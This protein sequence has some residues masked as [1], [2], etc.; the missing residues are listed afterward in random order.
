MES[1]LQALVTVIVEPPCV[2]FQS[3]S[4]AQLSS[5]AGFG[6]VLAPLAIT[7]ADVTLEGLS[8]I[9]CP[10]DTLCLRLSLDA[11]YASQS[12]E[13]LEVSLGGLVGATR[14][15]ATLGSCIDSEPQPLQATLT[16]NST[17][18]CMLVSIRIPTRAYSADLHVAV[19][20]AGQRLAGHPLARRLY[21]GFTAPLVLQRSTSTGG[22]GTTP[23][24][25]LQGRVYCPPGDGPEVV[26]F[27]K[28]G[29]PLPDLP[30]VSVGLSNQ[31]RWSAFA[32]GDS[33]TLL[34]AD[35]R[36]P[37]VAVDPVG[38]AIRWKCAE[39]SFDKCYGLA[40]L[41]S[42]GVVVSNHRSHLSAYRLT[43]GICLGRSLLVTGGLDLFLAADP[44]T[45]TV[46]GARFTGKE[47][48][49]T[50]HDVHSWSCVSV[51]GG[52][53]ITSAESVMFSSGA[54]S[55]PLAVM[56]AASGTL[57]SYLV[58]GSLDTD[59][60]RVISLPGLALVHTHRLEGMQV[61]GLA[62]DPWGSALAVCDGVSN[63][64][65]ILAW[66]LLGMRTPP[67]S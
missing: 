44:A 41:P 29:A 52:I 58:I 67:P 7:A 42:L 5:I 47:R 20:V 17:Q 62:A 57:N 43:D 63:T 45:G 19:Y 61:T 8:G 24:V 16:P 13:E 30:V 15:E 27:D 1:R 56:P 22:V 23:C 38:Y 9:V 31:T 53:R 46:Y 3:L 36:H 55:H 25:S 64:T 12:A 33:P 51:I 4:V 60:L 34:L 40:I 6:R 65:H 32:H 49:D 10:G 28:D 48:S 21:N 37:L 54:I 14:V 35:C 18:R 11:R 66:P 2:G 50:G 26:V 59:E 39:R